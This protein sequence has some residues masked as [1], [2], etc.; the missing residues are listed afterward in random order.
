MAIYDQ[1]TSG[2]SRCN[3]LARRKTARCRLALFILVRH[4]RT[5]LGRQVRAREFSPKE[6]PSAGNEQAIRQHPFACRTQ[7]A[8]E[9]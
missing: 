7:I 2:E 5:F 9:E 4:F 6:A 8:D 1:F 3:A